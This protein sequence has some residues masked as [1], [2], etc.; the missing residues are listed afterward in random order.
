MPN[1]RSASCDEQLVLVAE[2][3][4]DGRR[5]RAELGPDAAHRHLPEALAVRDGLRRV[6]DQ[7]TV[8]PSPGTLVQ[9]LDGRALLRHGAA[10]YPRVH[11]EVNCVDSA[12]SAAANPAGR[13]RPG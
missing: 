12:L 3:A 1:S 6:E 10:P 13:A 11:S 8:E 9:G 2:V 4:V 5:I 7:L